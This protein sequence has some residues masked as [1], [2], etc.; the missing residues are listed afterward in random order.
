MA[1][2]PQYLF[3]GPDTTESYRDRGNLKKITLPYTLPTAFFPGGATLTVGQDFDDLFRRLTV[4]NSSHAPA[5]GQNTHTMQVTPPPITLTTAQGHFGRQLNVNGSVYT[6]GA[7]FGS[8]SAFGALF[9]CTAPAGRCLKIQL[10]D[11][12]IR[13][14]DF[15]KE[16]I[17]NHIISASTN[18]DIHED[19][20]YAP[21]IH[22]MFLL[23]YGHNTY[24]CYIVD[25]YTKSINTITITKPA[26]IQISRKLDRLWELYQFNHGDSHSGNFLFYNAG[27]GSYSYVLTDFGFSELTLRDSLDHELII[28]TETPAPYI[29]KEGRDLSLLCL[30]LKFQT[31][32]GV[33]LTNGNPLI[34]ASGLALINAIVT[35]AFYN[36]VRSYQ[37]GF[38]FPQSI[39]SYMNTYDNPSAHPRTVLHAYNN[40]PAPGQPIRDT[41]CISPRVPIPQTYFELHYVKSD[42][43]LIRQINIPILQPQSARNLHTTITGMIRRDNSRLFPAGSVSRA[44]IVVRSPYFVGAINCGNNPRTFVMDNTGRPAAFNSIE[45]INDTTLRLIHT[46]PN[47][48]RDVDINTNVFLY[49]SNNIVLP[50]IDTHCGPPPVAAVPAPAPVPVAPPPPP[51][52]LASIGEAA[53]AVVAAAR[54]AAAPAAPAPVLP[55]IGETA[56]AVVVAARAT[57]PAPA[58]PSI[59]E[60]APAV[61][62]AAEAAERA[63]AEARARAVAEAEARAVAEAEA[64][65]RAAAE[66]AERAA[67]E[68]AARVRAAAE[69]A[70]IAAAEIVAEPFARAA[71][72]AAVEAYTAAAVATRLA[73]NVRNAFINNLARDAGARL[74]GQLARVVAADAEAKEQ[75]AAQERE[76]PA[77]RAARVRIDAAV[78]RTE[79]ALESARRA[80]GAEAARAGV[81]AAQAAWRRQ[82][83]REAEARAAAAERNAAAARQAA[84][85]ADATIQRKLTE[86]TPQGAS[87]AKI[88]D[89]ASYIRGD[90][91]RAAPGRHVIL[92]EKLYDAATRKIEELYPAAKAYVE[93]HIPDIVQRINNDRGVTN[94]SSCNSKAIDIL[95]ATP[96]TFEPGPEKDAQMRDIEEIIKNLDDSFLDVWLEIAGRQREFGLLYDRYTSGSATRIYE[97]SKN[98]KKTFELRKRS[99]ALANTKIEESILRTPSCYYQAHH[100]IRSV[101]RAMAKQT[102][103]NQINSVAIG[104]FDAM[105]DTIIRDICERDDIKQSILDKIKET[106]ALTVAHW[107]KT[108]ADTMF[109]ISNANHELQP[110]LTII[111]G[112]GPI[113]ETDHITLSNGRTIDAAK[114]IYIE[115]FNKQVR[116][117]YLQF[118]V[119][120]AK[121][122]AFI[123]INGIPGVPAIRALYNAA[124]GAEGIVAGA[125]AGYGVH[126]LGFGRVGVA[127]GA[128]AGVVQARQGGYYTIDKKRRKKLKLTSRRRKYHS[129]KLTKRKKYY[130]RK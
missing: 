23:R 116:K 75:R 15:L 105:A 119:E 41:A 103:L 29:R 89:L 71:E 96:L 3:L 114:Q 43:S 52:A 49:I 62:A 84:A 104:D 60:A 65:A 55:S 98:V 128:L 61:V 110:Y 87:P 70:E 6:I 2:A 86:Q 45:Y 80:G 69:A 26:I 38:N 48:N 77:A 121:R 9:H 67:A 111:S 11:T 115:E 14:R 22:E 63:A 35:T 30:F 72:E 82:R 42:R 95:R 54:A 129:K 123:K 88:W 68:E 24:G 97:I 33:T 99:W 126:A 117:T 37:G 19:C 85:V 108:H 73:I 83:A 124:G 53:P 8:Q 79:A 106:G 64:R 92:D 118:A 10:L 7:S 127:I 50:S 18:I 59:G 66:A 51:P 101:I 27:P 20:Q 120:E 31:N 5:F 4:V 34:D 40:P 94:D 112:Y 57:A 17:I 107:I 76:A 44:Y 81:R 46:D 74:Q 28:K 90:Y 130:T 78:R 39:R 21:T 1:V 125:I 32:T 13:R 47:N 16:G 102:L 56:P 25:E 91:V 100:S 93:T 58:L 113:L 12:D 109:E 122:V 36:N